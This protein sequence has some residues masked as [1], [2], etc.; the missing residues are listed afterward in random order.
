ML[1]M[2]HP[3]TQDESPGTTRSRRGNRTG[4]ERASDLRAGLR[5][6]ARSIATTMRRRDEDSR[7][8]RAWRLG[9][10]CEAGSSVLVFCGW[11]FGHAEEVALHIGKSGPLHV[12]VFVQDIPFEDGTETDETRD[13]GLS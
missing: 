12:R 8:D 4:P 6:N 10:Q 2:P 13:L 11:V 7:S 3:G 5:V 1:W 9:R